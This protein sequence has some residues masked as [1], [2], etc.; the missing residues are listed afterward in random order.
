[1]R[2][3]EV[4][5]ILLRHG[6]TERKSKG[7][8]RQFVRTDPPPKRL[9]TVACHPGDIAKHDLRKIASQS[10]ISPDEFH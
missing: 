6:F 5:R 9:V 2:A 8:H 10:G 4:I 7:G 1:M 3:S